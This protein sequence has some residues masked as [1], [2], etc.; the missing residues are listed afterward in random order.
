MPSLNWAMVHRLRAY[1]LPFIFAVLCI[2][3]ALQAQKIE[4]TK[5]ADGTTLIH[6]PKLPVPQPG[7]PTRL[8]LK[9]DMI[10]GKRPGGGGPLIAQLR[11]VGVDE[12]ENI[13]TLDWQDNKIRIFDKGGQ[14]INTFGKK[15]QG[16][17]ELQ[18]PSRM[19]VSG[20]GKALILDLNKIA[21]YR[22]DGECIKEIL[23]AKAK[24]NHSRLKV[25]G[26][27][28]IYMDGFEISSSRQEILSVAKYDADLNP[29]T[30][31]GTYQ[32]TINLSSPNPLMPMMYFHATRDGRLFWL[33]TA[34]YEFHL[35]SA[36]GKP[37]ARIT[38]DYSVKKI[39]ADEQTKLIKDRYGNTPPSIQ[40]KFPEAYPP[41]Q[42]FVGDD[43]GRLYVGTYE[44][45]EKDELLFDVFDTEGRYIARFSLPQDENLFVVKKGKLYTLIQEDEDGDP[46]VKRYTMEWK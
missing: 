9:Q 30:T 31:L 19:A 17:K 25:D 34:Q 45:N 12:Q 11:S 3:P 20:D 13:W 4:I 23:L 8:L 33:V 27:G 46:V 42:Y 16:P 15:G 26:L 28:F 14:L 39:T 10:V 24:G 41:V 18:N 36:E 32:E 7:G 44:R 2:V 35:N 29:I 21:F 37:I 1:A 6:N 22:A 43:E 5:L 38:K 40:F